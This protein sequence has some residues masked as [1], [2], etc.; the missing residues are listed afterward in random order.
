MELGFALGH[1]GAGT[2][3][4]DE[5]GVNPGILPSALCV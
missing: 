2:L 3:A 1:G 5:A 4:G